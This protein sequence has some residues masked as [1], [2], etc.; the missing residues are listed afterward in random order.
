MRVSKRPDESQ[1][2]KSLL[3][4]LRPITRTQKKKLPDWKPLHDYH[5]DIWAS[6]QR[7]LLSSDRHPFYDVEKI[8]DQKVSIFGER[9]YKIRWLGYGPSEDSW[10]PAD[11]LCCPQKLI[12]FFDHRKKMEEM[13]MDTNNQEK[14]EVNNQVK[15]EKINDEKEKNDVTMNN[16]VVKKENII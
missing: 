12:E 11:H 5:P 7:Q 1:R 10:E 9:S 16:V 6:N 2:T 14:F 4:K 13:L 3:A 8:L 15:K